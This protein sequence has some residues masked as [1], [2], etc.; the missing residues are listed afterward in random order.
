MH[1]PDWSHAKHLCNSEADRKCLIVQRRRWL[2]I[3]FNK[4]GG[5]IGVILEFPVTLHFFLCSPVDLSHL[6]LGYPEVAEE[7]PRM[8]NAVAE[9]SLAMAE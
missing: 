1:L 9:E 5:I 7:F 6:A 4:A 8:F 2:L 3:V